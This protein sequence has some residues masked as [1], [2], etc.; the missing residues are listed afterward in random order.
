MIALLT[1][2]GPDN[3]Y[4]AQ[5]KGR[6]Y[7]DHS[8][9]TVVDIT[10]SITPQNIVEGAY[11]LRDTIEAFPTGTIFVAVVDPGVGTSR[12]ILLVKANGQLFIL[13]DNGLISVIGND[14]GLESAFEVCPERFDASATFHG[15][16][17]MAPLSAMLSRGERPGDLG[18][19]VDTNT[20]CHLEFNQPTKVELRGNQYRVEGQ[21]VYADCFGNLISNIGRKLLPSNSNNVCVRLDRWTVDHI[22]RTFGDVPAGELLAIVGSHGRLEIAVNQGNARIHCAVEPLEKVSV[23]WEENAE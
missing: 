13:P 22:H 17:I 9:A 15:R 16:D 21:I 1:D 8:A 20:L 4:V 6:I 11:V 23:E 2:F 18:S 5:M 10:H 14:Y 7:Q 3:H 12:R 19:P